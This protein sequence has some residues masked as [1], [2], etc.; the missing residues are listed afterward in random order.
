MEIIDFLNLTVRRVVSLVVLGLLVALPT[1]AILL[2]GPT[3]YRGTVTVRLS[4]L[5]PDGGA[6]YLWERLTQDFQ[7]ALQLPQVADEVSRQTGVDPDVVRAGLTTVLPQNGDV[8]TVTF[9]GPD[10]TRSLAVTR[11]ASTEALKV[12]TI[13]AVDETAARV[14]VASQTFDDALQGFQAYVA[15]SS[16]PDPVASAKGTLTLVLRLKSEAATS[17]GSVAA[18][19]QIALLE[20][21]LNALVAAAPQYRQAIETADA[22]RGAAKQATFDQVVAASQNAAAASGALVTP[23]GS[24]TV[25]RA[26]SVLTTG[27]GVGAAAVMSVLAF[28]AAIELRRGRRIDQLAVV[29]YPESEAGDAEQRAVWRSYRRLTFSSIGEKLTLIPPTVLRRGWWLLAPIG[30]LVSLGEAALLSSSKTVLAL[31]VAV[32]LGLGLA[33]LAVTRFEAFL[34]ALIVVRASLDA[35]NLA[36]P[37]GG[38]TGVDPGIVIGG[39]FT[40]CA[41]LWLLR[42]V[43]RGTGSRSRR[44]HGRCGR[45]RVRAC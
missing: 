14:K 43:A 33:V 26:T 7:T 28:L 8:V 9:R 45:S 32:P 18:S 5:L 40:L 15:L 11:A 17:D 29:L 35:F 25:S 1:T 10:A 41:A 34:M 39:V 42:S 2:R 27:M 24:E 13:Q 30:F 36:S 19:E 22:A 37:D 38:S 23:T 3:D 44:R 12:L 4:A 21:Q 6:F 31:V 20:A 16:D